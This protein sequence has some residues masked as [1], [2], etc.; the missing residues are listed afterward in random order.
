[1]AITNQP[2]KCSKTLGKIHGI[3]G[4]LSVLSPGVILGVIL[5]VLASFTIDTLR[6][7]LDQKHLPD[8]K[9]GLFAI[10]LSVGTYWT[11]VGHTRQKAWKNLTRA[12]PVPVPVIN[13]TEP[14][15][16]VK[17]HA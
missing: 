5:S 11:A 13:H 8:S 7:D 14:K 3:E 16:V 12:K 6:D 10:P 4:F 9:F 2:I 1:M 15:S 17:K